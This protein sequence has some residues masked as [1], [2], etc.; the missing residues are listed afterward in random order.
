MNNEARITYGTDSV[1][2]SVIPNA[3]RIDRIAIHVEPDGTVTVEAPANADVNDIHRAVHKRA[4]WVFSHVKDAQSRFVDVK[5]KAYV[6]GE[7]ILYLGRRYVLKVLAD[8]ERRSPARLKGNRLEVPA[9]GN[10]A[11]IIRAKVWAWYRVKGRDYFERR[12]S[13]LASSLPWVSMAPSFEIKTMEKRW[14]SCSSAGTLI[15]NPHLIKAP[16]DCIDYVLLHELAHLK[17]HDHGPAFWKLVENADPDWM[18]KKKRLDQM[19]EVL[20]SR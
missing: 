19:A 8:G 12:I 3:K 17:H 2:Y 11:T 5:P 6:S 1:P 9:G 14:G 20:F 16:R 13:T 15:L 7:E 4:R 10:E 18:P